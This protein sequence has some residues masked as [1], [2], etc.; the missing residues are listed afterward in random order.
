MNGCIDWQIDHDG[1]KKRYRLRDNSRF[2]EIRRKGQSFSNK[3]LVLCVMSN[4]LGHSRFG[5]S[6]SKRIGNAVFRNRFKRQLRE[7]MRLRLHTVQPGWDFVFIARQGIRGANY[8]EMDAACAR[9]VRRANLLLLE[10]EANHPE[11]LTSNN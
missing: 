1:M 8:H 5:F 6:I 11:N 2:Q 7:A 4:D 10:E 9:L 3:M